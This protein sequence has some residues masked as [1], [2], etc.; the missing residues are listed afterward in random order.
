MDVLEIFK[1]SPKAR[2]VAAGEVLFRRG[3][4]ANEMYVVLEGQVDVSLDG[5]L[6]ES[7]PPG[8]ILG[9]MGIVD[10]GPRSADAIAATDARIEVIDKAWFCTLIKR[11]PEFGLHVMS[12][13]AERLRRHMQQVA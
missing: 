2:R 4:A 6:V 12:V 5:R 1:D 3:D 7:L 9:E 10:Q 11:A 13:M 8:S